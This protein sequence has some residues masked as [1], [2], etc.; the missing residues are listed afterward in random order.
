MMQDMGDSWQACPLVGNRIVLA[1]M[2]RRG[3]DC[4][5]VGVR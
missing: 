3:L 2:V 1:V 5:D 4:V